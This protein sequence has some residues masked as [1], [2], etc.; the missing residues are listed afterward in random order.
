MG[1]R[2]LYVEIETLILEWEKGIASKQ[3]NI[4]QF[5]PWSLP[6]LREAFHFNI[7]SLLDA[8]WCYWQRPWLNKKLASNIKVT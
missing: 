8:K 7:Q 2:I 3:K 4:I 1:W 6:V 5:L